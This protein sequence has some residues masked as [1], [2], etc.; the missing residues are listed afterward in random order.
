MRK[1]CYPRSN[2]PPVV[3]EGETRRN[4][5]QTSNNEKPVRRVLPGKTSVAFWRSRGGGDGDCLCDP[6]HLHTKY[7]QEERFYP[8]ERRR[9]TDARA[10]RRLSRG[11]L[12]FSFLRYASTALPNTIPSTCTPVIAGIYSPFKAVPQRLTLHLALAL[13]PNLNLNLGPHPQ[14][15]PHFFVACAVEKGGLR[16]TNPHP[17]RWSSGPVGL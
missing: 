10:R 15:E 2:N 5:N 16:A 7:P 17:Q 3:S 6:P 14:P 4:K 1:V 9:K 8:P 11:N 12:W 13:S